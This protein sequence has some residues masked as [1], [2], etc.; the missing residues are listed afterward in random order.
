MVMELLSD[1]HDMGNTVLMVTHNPELTRY[2]SR[3]LYMYDGAIQHDVQKQVGVAATSRQTKLFAPE[4]SVEDD[5]QS[6]AAKMA[7]EAEKESTKPQ[8]TKTKRSKRSAKSKRKV[9][10]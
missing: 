5:L 7:L 8:T 1:I 6:V 2:A 9:K 4:G 10:G 3:V